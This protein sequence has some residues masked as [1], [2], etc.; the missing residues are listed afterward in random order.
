M[1]TVKQLSDLAGI[2]RRTL[3]YYD[4][5]DLLK[6][7]ETGS[8]GY[9]YYGEDAILRLQQILLYRQLGLSLDMIRKI[10]NNPSFDVIA[11]LQNHKKELK[12][13]V[14]QLQRLEK[15]VDDTI[16]YIEG[17]KQMSQKQ[18]FEAFSEEEQAKYEEEAKQMYDPE[19]V[20]TSN[21][22]WRKLTDAEKQQIG[23]ESN[24]VYRDILQAMPNGA[25]SPEVQA[26]I[27]RWR[28]HMEHFWSPNDDQL[29]GLANLYNDDPRFK[30]NFDKI[31]PQLAAFMR[32]AVKIYVEKRRK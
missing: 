11:A 32:E 22:K 8:N 6:P 18:L 20:K 27:E 21:E 9:R 25:S 3:H 10:L 13:R 12:K 31:D 2:T 24:T 14:D 15:T 7:T 30:A 1:L 23:E 4:E 29:L 5:I 26:C 17:K 19:I 28:K 16:L